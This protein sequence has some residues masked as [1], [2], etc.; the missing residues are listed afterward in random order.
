MKQAIKQW[1]D[2]ITVPEEICRMQAEYENK[3][4]KVCRIGTIIQLM[5]QDGTVDIWWENGA[6][7]Q[8]IHE[9]EK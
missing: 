6:F 4:Y 2:P 7:W 8:E 1:I 5:L 9:N 3:G